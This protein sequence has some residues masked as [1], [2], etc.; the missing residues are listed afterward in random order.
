MTSTVRVDAVSIL[1]KE[2][3]T[4]TKL[5]SGGTWSFALNIDVPRSLCYRTL[6][7]CKA[8]SLSTIAPMWTSLCQSYA[9]TT[10][11]GAVTID[12]DV[13]AHNSAPVAYVCPCFSFVDFSD[14]VYKV[15]HPS[16][17]DDLKRVSCFALASRNLT[18]LA[19]ATRLKKSVSYGFRRV[20]F[21]FSHVQLPELSQIW[22]SALFGCSVTTISTNP[23][24]VSS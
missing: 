6:T 8:S 22:D 9:V 23:S 3:L 15:D 2:A 17:A 19:L 16:Q 1:P 10:F 18:L 12:Y 4:T 5:Y 7:C 24:G 13:C 20:M 11:P 14:F 21:L